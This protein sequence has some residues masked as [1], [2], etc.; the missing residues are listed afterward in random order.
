MPRS[1]ATRALLLQVSSVLLWA[2]VRALIV[3]DTDSAIKFDNTWVIDGN[4]D[5]SGGSAHRTNISSGTASY[6]FQ[7]EPWADVF[8]SPDIRRQGFALLRYTRALFIVF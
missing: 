4:G 5:N 7:G 8:T 3:Q 1:V 6:Q 2:S